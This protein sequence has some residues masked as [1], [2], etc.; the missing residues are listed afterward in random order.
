[1]TVTLMRNLPIT[2]EGLNHLRAAAWEGLQTRD[3]NPIFERSLGWVGATDDDRLIGFANVAS[4]GGAHAFLLDI[5]VHPHYQRR[6]IGTAL[7]R[8]ASALAHDCGSEWLHVDYEA[9]LE[10][11]YR[12]CGFRPTSAGILGLAAG[13]RA[14]ARIGR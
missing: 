12:A 9:D 13:N 6:G 2:S 14:A 5:T 3:W 4:D 8:E 10:P 7:V 1:M 11:F